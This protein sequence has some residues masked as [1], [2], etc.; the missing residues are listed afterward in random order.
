MEQRYRT[1]NA[2]RDLS[3]LWKA[4]RLNLRCAT[5]IPYQKVQTQSRRAALVALRGMDRVIPTSRTVSRC[6]RPRKAAQYITADRFSHV[7]SA[8]GDAT[9]ISCPF[10]G[11]GKDLSVAK[12]RWIPRLFY[13][14]SPNPGYLWECLNAALKLGFLASQ[15]IYTTSSRKAAAIHLP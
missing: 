4:K 12:F 5:R 10:L 13:V 2:N 11:V 15:P 6:S 14:H 8:P 3:P 7:R 9:Q 1:R